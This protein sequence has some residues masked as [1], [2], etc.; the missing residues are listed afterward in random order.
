MIKAI[1]FDVGNVILKVDNDIFLEKISDF[2]EKSVEELSELIYGSSNLAVRYET[3][4]IS[5]DGFYDEACQLCNLSISKEEFRK[6]FTGIFTLMPET[7]ELIK[8]LSGKYKLGL[9]SNTNEWD[10]E[11]AI[12][13][14]EVFDLFDAVT[15]S[16]K[17]GAMKPEKAIYLDS[18]KKLGL[19]PEE[20]VYMDDVERYAQAAT[21]LGMRGLHYVSHGKLIADLNDLGSLSEY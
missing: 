14:L 10:F 1:I 7:V 13:K 17:V 18:L 3:G 4:E 11:D 21:D 5:S 19:K 8:G 6:A 20:C 2:T 12:K 9:L 15:V 16:Y